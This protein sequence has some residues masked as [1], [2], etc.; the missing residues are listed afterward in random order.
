MP[1]LQ[2][3]PPANMLAYV[4]DHDYLVD[5]PEYKCLNDLLVLNITNDQ[6]SEIEVSTR[7]QSTNSAWLDERSKRIQSSFFGKICKAT[8]KTDKDKLAH[9]L[10]NPTTFSTP[11]V[12]CGRQYENVAVK[13]Y[14]NIT[15]QETT[16]CGIYVYKDFPFL[17]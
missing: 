16:E 5:T 13:K 1:I 15:N 8:N 4:H 7:G 3:V 6:I 12:L 2:I 10:V 14:E 11:S 17:G 9:S